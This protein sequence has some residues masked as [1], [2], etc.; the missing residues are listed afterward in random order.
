MF[1]R[2][3][4]VTVIVSMGLTSVPNHKQELSSVYQFIDVL[5]NLRWVLSCS[6]E[7]LMEFYDPLVSSDLLVYDV[8]AYLHCT[9]QRLKYSSY[10]G[11]YWL[12]PNLG[13]YWL[14]LHEC[15]YWPYTL[16]SSVRLLT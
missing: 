8:Y 6:G 2:Y 13:N 12:L 15:C 5:Y 14:L 10:L 11:N 4:S 3:T 7:R 9:V 1:P 16:V